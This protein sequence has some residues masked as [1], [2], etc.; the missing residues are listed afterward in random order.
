MSLQNHLT[1]SPG[2]MKLQQAL[3]A[4]HA[5]D[6]DDDEDARSTGAS[7]SSISTAS[8]AATTMGALRALRLDPSLAR[9][10]GR[11]DKG[12]S[13]S[14]SDLGD[15]QGSAKGLSSKS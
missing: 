7:A 8:T 9:S 3:M 6:I 2:V 5:E 13:A 15:G 12:C 14:N 10:S 1:L 4:K 11:K